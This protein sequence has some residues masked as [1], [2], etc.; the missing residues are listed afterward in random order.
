VSHTCILLGLILLLSFKTIDPIK[1]A[2][3]TQ[4]KSRGVNQGVHT[5]DRALIKTQKQPRPVSGSVPQKGFQHLRSE[6]AENFPYT[7]KANIPFILDLRD[8]A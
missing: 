2:R 3:S 1:K 6:S 5:K 7:N 8:M 4:Q